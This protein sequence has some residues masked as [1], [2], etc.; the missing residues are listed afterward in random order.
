MLLLIDK[1]LGDRDRDFSSTTEYF[2]HVVERDWEQLIRQPNSVCGKDDAMA[3]YRTF[4]VLKSMIPN[5]V[6][7]KYDRTKFKIICDDLG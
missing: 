2:Q 3:K 4:K 7:E 1:S 5:F 6:N